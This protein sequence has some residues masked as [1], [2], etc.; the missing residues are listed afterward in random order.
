MSSGPSAG[1]LKN[2]A[3]NTVTP[4]VRALPTLGGVE[5]LYFNTFTLNT[6]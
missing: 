4:L 1:A 2:V 3:T 5:P 6:A